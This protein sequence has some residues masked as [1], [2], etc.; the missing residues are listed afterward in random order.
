M[1]FVDQTQAAP[2]RDH[3]GAPNTPP[4]SLD[5]KR[6]AKRVAQLRDKLA[7]ALEDPLTRDQIVKAIR[8]MINQD[9]S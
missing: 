4:E 1:H 3:G 2:P 5:E 8:A 9:R 6:A 7:N